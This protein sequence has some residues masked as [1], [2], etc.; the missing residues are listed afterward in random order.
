MFAI[1]GQIEVFWEYNKGVDQDLGS[2][3]WALGLHTPLV[4]PLT[5]T[6]HHIHQIGIMYF[7]H[8]Y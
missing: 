3:L 7:M 5:F 1:L 6:Q 4:K 2:G 8:Y